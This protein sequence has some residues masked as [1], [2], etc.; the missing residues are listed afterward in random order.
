M[1]C[2]ISAMQWHQWQPH[3]F[4]SLFLSVLTCILF[5]FHGMTRFL[6]G[7]PCLHNFL[8]FTSAFTCFH[9]FS[10][11]FTRFTCFHWYRRYYPHM[12]RDSVSPICGI[13]TMYIVC[14]ALHTALHCI[15]TVYP[16]LLHSAN[17]SSLL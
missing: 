2:C 3:Q 10:L 6:P 11:I 17:C 13:L 4:L 16:S 7:L 5:V 12:S 9:M 14:C 1:Q 15:S 8:P